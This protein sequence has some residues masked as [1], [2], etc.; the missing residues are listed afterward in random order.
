MQLDVHRQHHRVAGRGGV[1]CQ[2]AD[3]VAA[4]RGLQPLHARLTVQRL[5]IRRLDAELAD[6]IGAAV[7]GGVVRIL[8]AFLLALVDAADVADQMAAGFAQRV[9]AK[10]PC[11]DVHARKAVALRGEARHLVVGQAGADGDGLEALGVVHQAL[12]LAPVTCTDLDDLAQL[13]DGVFQVAHLGACDL[14]R[15][16][17]IVRG[18]QH[19]VAIQNQA[20]IGHDGDDRRAVALGLFG[21][22]VMAHHLQHDQPREDQRKSQQDEEADDDHPQSEA[23][24]VCLHIA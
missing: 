19:A 1:A 16:G 14:Q 22:I 17:R 21:Q 4:R 15:I 12:E 24:D 23:G 13:V 20:A 3:G 7:I 18:Q 10:Q 8:D 11:L 5:F 6:V 2:A 9:V